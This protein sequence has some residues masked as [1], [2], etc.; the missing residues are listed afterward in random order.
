MRIART[1]AALC[2]I[3]MTALLLTACDEEETETTEEPRSNRE[4]VDELEEKYK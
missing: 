2:L 1:L 4:T 3:A